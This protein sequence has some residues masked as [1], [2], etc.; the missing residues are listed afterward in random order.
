MYHRYGRHGPHAWKRWRLRKFQRLPAVVQQAVVQPSRIVQVR[1]AVPINTERVIFIIMTQEGTFQ[2]YGEFPPGDGEPSKPSVP[3]PDA[4]DE[5]KGMLPHP[6]RPSLLQ[7]LAEKQAVD[8]GYKIRWLIDQGKYILLRSDY[9]STLAHIYASHDITADRFD[10]SQYSQLHDE[11]ERFYTTRFRK[12]IQP[13]VAIGRIIDIA[14][15]YVSQLRAVLSQDRE[16]VKT[17]APGDWHARDLVLMRILQVYH[18]GRM[19]QLDADTLL[20]TLLQHHALIDYYERFVL[21]FTEKDEVVW[22][23]LNSFRPA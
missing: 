18:R 7:D 5:Q 10:L 3:P 4:L 19:D 16:F 9:L 17:R 6:Q 1:I 11:Y 13:Y 15:S 8:D 14:D 21:D 22:P 23:D 2:G 12:A 20:K